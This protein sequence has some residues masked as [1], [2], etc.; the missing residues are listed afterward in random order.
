MKF[1]FFITHGFHQKSYISI[2]EYR[3]NA[4]PSNETMIVY[5]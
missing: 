5:Q 4:T 1:I 2:K 3:W